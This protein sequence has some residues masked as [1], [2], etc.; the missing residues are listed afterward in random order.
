M[1][2]DH[3]VQ[4]EVDVLGI[5]LSIARLPADAGTPP[6]AASGSWY[7]VTRSADELSVV[8]ESDL[9]P[10]DVQCNGPWRALKVAGPLDFALTGI[11]SRL[12]RPLAEAGIPIFALSTFDTDYILVREESVTDA[13]TCLSEAGIVVRTAD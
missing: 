7:S 11:L 3:G 6:W 9:V 5:V 4:L 2:A 8:C 13:K 12:A 10:C 1:P